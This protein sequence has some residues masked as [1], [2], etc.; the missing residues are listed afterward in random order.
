MRKKL[1]WTYLWLSVSLLTTV[2]SYATWANSCP[3]FWDIWGRI[4]ES[5]SNGQGGYSGM[6]AGDGIQYVGVFVTALFVSVAFLLITKFVVNLLGLT[7]ERK[8]N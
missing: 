8:K 4:P 2:A 1:L 3:D 7:L 5:A 6:C